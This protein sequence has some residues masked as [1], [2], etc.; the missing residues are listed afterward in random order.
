MN[1]TGN[2]K[3]LILAVLIAVVLYL[4]YSQKSNKGSYKQENLSND[5]NN[6]IESFDESVCLDSV[7]SDLTG[8]S[9]DSSDSSNDSSCDSDDTSVPA[10]Q[11][12]TLDK[13]SVKKMLDKKMKHVDSAKPGEYKRS[14]YACNKRDQVGTQN[15]D[16]FFEL[17]NPFNENNNNDFYGNDEGSNLAAYAGCGSKKLSDEEKFNSSALLPK[18][19]NNDWF[20]TCADTTKGLSIKNRHLINTNRPMGVSTISTQRKN[21]S[22]DVRGNPANPKYVVSP[23]L[24]SS[25]EPDINASGICV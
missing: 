12:P 8:N 22:Y 15:L 3:L 18:E 5:D 14:S 2:Q 10:N 25:Y 9:N 24:N 21:P 6:S 4:I 23:F 19:N 11:E 13:T 17:G 16:D 7:T 1:L 20:D